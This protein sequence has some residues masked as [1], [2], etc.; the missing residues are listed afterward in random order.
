MSY[1]SLICGLEARVLTIGDRF[2]GV[3]ATDNFHV[4]QTMTLKLETKIIFITGSYYR[5][6][7]HTSDGSRTSITSPWTV[8]NSVSKRPLNAGA[9]LRVIPAVCSLR[10]VGTSNE[11][12]RNVPTVVQCRRKKPSVYELTRPRVVCVRKH[13][14]GSRRAL[15]VTKSCRVAPLRPDATLHSTWRA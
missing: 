12:T 5:G 13:L 8:I 6:N 14:V 4:S 10:R 9:I 7:N 11:G 15:V 1:C 3:G 2:I